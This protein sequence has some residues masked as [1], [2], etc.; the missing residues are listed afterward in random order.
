MFK[1]EDA[2]SK[3]N[4]SRANK[5]KTYHPFRSRPLKNRNM[6]FGQNW[7][8]KFIEETLNHLTAKL[9]YLKSLKL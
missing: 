7:H 9:K 8:Q 2:I 5:K 4:T 6:V 3:Q 1:K